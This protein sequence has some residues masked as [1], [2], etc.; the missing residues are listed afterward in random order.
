MIRRRMAILAA[1]ALLAA[2]GGSADAGP[3]VVE[4]TAADGTPTSLADFDGTPVV[5]NLWATWC[6][7]CLAEMPVFDAAATALAGRVA[8]IGVN[9]GDDRAEVDAFADRLGVDYPMFTDPDGLLSAALGVTQLPA[10]AFVAGDGTLLEVH[11][12]AY[13]ADELDDAITRTFPEVGS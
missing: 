4:F 5:V 3:T 8:V 1:T 6:A 12:G 7:P 10:T 13:T 9:V 11:R 2:C